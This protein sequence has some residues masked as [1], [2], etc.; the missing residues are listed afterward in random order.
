MYLRQSALYVFPE[1]SF[2]KQSIPKRFQKVPFE[3]SPLE[4]S[5]VPFNEKAIPRGRFHLLPGRR[6]STGA[7]SAEL[8]L[9]RRGVQCDA[10][11]VVIAETMFIEIAIPTN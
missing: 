2:W 4:E 3:E 11:G 7:L 5:P 8:Q 10:R 1:A 6:V 9:R